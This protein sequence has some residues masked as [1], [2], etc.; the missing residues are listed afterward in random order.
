MYLKGISV[1]STEDM[2]LL[3]ELRK[4]LDLIEAYWWFAE[5]SVDGFCCANTIGA[6]SRFE[7]RDS[8]EVFDLI[9]LLHRRK[10]QNG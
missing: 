3:E 5:N 9:A 6:K 4:K 1:L 10:E 8:K 7:A 2:E